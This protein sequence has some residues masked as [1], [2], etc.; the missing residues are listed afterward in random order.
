MEMDESIS[1]SS[2]IDK[3]PPSWKDFKHMLKHKKEELSLVQ[4]GGHLLIEEFLR[5]QEGVK[6]KGK[7]TMESPSI[8]MMDVGKSSKSAKG[9]K[10]PFHNTD[11]N[12]NKKPKGACWIC[13]K[14]GHFKNDY[15][16]K[17][18]N[19]GTKRNPIGQGSKD[20]G[21]P[22]HQGHIFDNGINRIVNYIPLISE[23]F[24]VQDDD[25]A[26]WVDS[27][28]TWNA[29]K[30]RRWFKTYEPVDDGSILYMGN[31]STTPI[32]GRGVVVLEFSKCGTFV[33]YKQ[34]WN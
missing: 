14:T 15:R 1:V 4:L 8:N 33:G 22:T 3:L 16:M 5:A 31:E 6:G 12:S 21:P 11:N 26:W 20:Q 13:G 9:K 32:L 25:V 28:A 29:C 19:K 10:R 34:V 2:I 17:K 7:E 23:A 27:G 24:Y 30:D 18:T